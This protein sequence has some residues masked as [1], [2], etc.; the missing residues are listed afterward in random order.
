MSGDKT[1]ARSPMA[2]RRCRPS[3]QDPPDLI[4][5]DIT[6]PEMDGLEVCRRAE[7]DRILPGTCR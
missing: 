4:L 6:M 3:E 5:L 7:R 1:C 2:A